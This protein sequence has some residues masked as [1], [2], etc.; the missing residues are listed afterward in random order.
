[1]ETGF[2]LRAREFN[3]CLSRSTTEEGNGTYPNGFEYF[4]PSVIAQVIK[5]TSLST[6]IYTAIIIMVALIKIITYLASEYVSKR[7]TCN[8]LDD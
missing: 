2:L 1:M 8:Q 4:C 6:D 5:S 7:T 3:V